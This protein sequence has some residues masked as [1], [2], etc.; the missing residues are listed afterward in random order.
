MNLDEPPLT[1]MKLLV[2]LLNLY[3]F[4]DNFMTFYDL[5][6]RI[7][8]LPY[9]LLHSTCDLLLITYGSLAIMDFFIM[10]S[11]DDTLRFG[12]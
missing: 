7:N 6:L 8:D 5:D 11:L 12:F 3:A 1:L 9:D 2:C 10:I 4:I